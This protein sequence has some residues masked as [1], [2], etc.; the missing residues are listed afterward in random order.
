[1]QS[2]RS[3][4]APTSESLC[5][6]MPPTSPTMKAVVL[7]VDDAGNRRLRL[8]NAYPKP[9]PTKGEVLL[10][11]ILAGI[12]DTDL[13]IQHGYKSLSRLV[14][15][16][17]FVARLVQFGPDCASTSHLKE[18]DRVVAEINC[19]PHGS[20]SRTAFERAQDCYRTALGIFG[21]DGVF[22]EFVCVPLENVHKVPD[23]VPDIDAVLVEPLAAACQIYEQIEVS[24][25]EKIAIVGAGRLAWLVAQTMVLRAKD[26]TVFTFADSCEGK[27]N[28]VS[29]EHLASLCDVKLMSAADVCS[30]PSLQNHFDVVV[31]CSFKPS[32]VGI[33]LQLVKPRGTIVLKSA[34]APAKGTNASDLSLAVVKEVN[35]V[36]S[37]CGPFPVALKLLAEKRVTP[38]KLPREIQS[39]ECVA[40]AFER[41]RQADSLKVLLQM[42]RMTLRAAAS[43]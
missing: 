33:A 13:E 23:H 24:G 7:S 36:G 3:R 15:G 5:I 17:E 34:T 31:E 39:V 35:L 22:A 28:G 6:A 21:R 25:I 42:S 38:A 27:Q 16:H 9:V 30:I 20:L 26:V 19:V 18:G 37:R 1:M 29:D 8:D 10:E 41:T 2:A 4:R 14:L 11:V 40:E 12:C 43:A 32:G